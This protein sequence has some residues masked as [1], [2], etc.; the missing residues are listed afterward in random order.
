MWLFEI[1]LSL[2]LIPNLYPV[3]LL[4]SLTI[5]KSY[6]TDIW[7]IF[8]LV[9][10]VLTNQIIYSFFY[11][12]YTLFSS[13][14]SFIASVKTS[15][16]MWNKRNSTGHPCVVPNFTGK[17]S[18]FTIKNDVSGKGYFVVV[19]W[20]VGLLLFFFIKQELISVSTLFW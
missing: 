5:S 1:S 2:S 16:I 15:S 12:V 17:H 4:N 19:A 13:L 9:T 6:F 8:I 10:M 3:N 7:G 20:L 14:S 18:V 11:N